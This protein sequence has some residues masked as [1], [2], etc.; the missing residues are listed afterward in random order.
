[1]AGS[2]GGCREKDQPKG[3]YLAWQ[4]TSTQESS[5]RAQA[6]EAERCGTRAI[7]LKLD[8]LNLNLQKVQIGTR[9]KGA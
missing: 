7:W 4:P 8:C 6:H 9:R 5:G 2:G 1:M 3:R